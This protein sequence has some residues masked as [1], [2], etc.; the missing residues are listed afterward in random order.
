MHIFCIWSVWTLTHSKYECS[1]DLKFSC[2]SPLTGKSDDRRPCF[3][4]C[5]IGDDC[6]ICFLG[7]FSRG[8]EDFWVH[9][10]VS[11]KTWPHGLPCA[12]HSNVH[13]FSL[14]VGELDLAP[15]IVAL[16]EFTWCVLSFH[17]ALMFFFNLNSIMGNFYSNYWDRG[18][19]DQAC[20]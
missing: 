12:S 13:M 1:A 6:H 18:W 3:T 2:H 16:M 7:R 14:G 11:L 4:C 20:K 15:R 19:I 8:T 17:T 9:L 5:G 10:P